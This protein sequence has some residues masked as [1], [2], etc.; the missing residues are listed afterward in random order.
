M[1]KKMKEE[2][3]TNIED[4]GEEPIEEHDGDPSVGNNPPWVNKWGASKGSDYTPV[5]GYEAHAEALSDTE[6]LVYLDIGG[7][8]PADP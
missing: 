8:D 6:Y 5:K 1:K 4:R 3:R 7:G 2:M